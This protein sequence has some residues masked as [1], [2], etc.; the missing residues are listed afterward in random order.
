MD[1]STP[2]ELDSPAVIADEVAGETLVINLNTGCYYV[3]VPSA[4]HVWSLIS[5][6]CAPADLLAGPGD[7][8]A[9]ALTTFM[10]TI[11]QAQLLRPAAATKTGYTVPDWRAEDLAIAEHTDMADLLALDPIHDADENL[12]WPMRPSG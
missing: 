11:H 12:G 3:I 6:G 5:S 7:A 2:L 8:R 9:Q 10:A 4:R 1:L